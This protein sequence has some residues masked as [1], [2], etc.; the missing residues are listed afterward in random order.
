MINNN[1][2]K[3]LREKTGHGI[4]DCKKALADAG[5]DYNKAKEILSAQVEKM[6]QKKSERETKA[7]LIETY[8]HGDGRVGVILEVNCESDFV[9]RNEEFK[10]LAHNLVMQ[11]AAMNPKN[12]DELLEQEWVIDDGTQKV[13]PVDGLLVKDLIKTKIAKLKENIKIIR[14][15]RYE[16]GE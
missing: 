13:T 4:M 1:D 14:F 9:A 3:K 6:A 15:E 16:L 7:G 10:T 5:G 11:I 12:I 2:V 8:V